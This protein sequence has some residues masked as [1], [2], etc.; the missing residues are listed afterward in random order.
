MLLPPLST[1]QES[2]RLGPRQHGLFR[3]ISTLPQWLRRRARDWSQPGSKPREQTSNKRKLFSGDARFRVISMKTLV[4][5]HTPMDEHLLRAVRSLIVHRKQNVEHCEPLIDSD[6]DNHGKRN[7][8]GRD[9]WMTIMSYEDVGCLA[10]V[11]THYSNPNVWIKLGDCCR[12]HITGDLGLSDNARNIVRNMVR[13]A[14]TRR[15]TSR[16][17]TWSNLLN[18]C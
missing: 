15:I 3:R 9:K 18:T 13:Y 12:R 4:K 17:L 16:S 8:Y 6:G 14:S 10:P 2:I 7:C 11:I 1:F 5:C